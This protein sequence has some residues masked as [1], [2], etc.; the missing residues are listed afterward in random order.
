MADIGERA[1]HEAAQ[2]LF[3]FRDQDARHVGYQ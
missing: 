3:V 1:P 2:R